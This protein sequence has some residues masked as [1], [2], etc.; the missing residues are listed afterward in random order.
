MAYVH[1]QRLPQ[2]QYA[3][4]MLASIG[5]FSRARKED[6]R[7]FPSIITH[8]TRMLPADFSNARFMS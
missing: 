1:T 5:A 2:R 7:G 8:T 4:E 6:M 3:L